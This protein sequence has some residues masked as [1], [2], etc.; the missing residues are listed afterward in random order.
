MDAKLETTFPPSC[1]PNG[2]NPREIP[3]LKRHMPIT[4]QDIPIMSSSK[5]FG[6][7]LKP[8]M[9]TRRRIEH[10]GTI[11]HTA[12]SNAPLSW[13]GPSSSPFPLL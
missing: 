9:S 1:S 11:A 4:A 7:C 2:V 13:S 5:Y 3:R 8:P 12:P 6:F 10:K